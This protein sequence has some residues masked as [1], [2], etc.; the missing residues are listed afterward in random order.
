MIEDYD[1]FDVSIGIDVCQGNHGAD[2]IDRNGM[3]LLDRTLPQADGIMVGSIPAVV[4]N[5][6]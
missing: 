6:N 5:A 3:K 2:A 1:Q 4:V